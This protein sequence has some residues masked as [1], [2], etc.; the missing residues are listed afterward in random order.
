MTE[1]RTIPTPIYP[2]NQ[3]IDRL[4]MC[5]CSMR[6]HTSNSMTGSVPISAVSTGNQGPTLRYGRPEA[7]QVSVVGTFNDWQPGMHLL[8]ARG[9]SGIWEGFIPEVRKG[10]LYKYHI[11]SHHATT[12]LTRRSTGIL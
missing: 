10:T 12:G 6:A 5:I 11:L 7:E 4:M 9:H 1:H 3:Q 2:L 8:Q